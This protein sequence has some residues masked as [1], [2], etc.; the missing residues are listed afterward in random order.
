MAKLFS[1]PDPDA[2]DHIQV[3]TIHKSQGLEFDARILPSMRQL[4]ERRGEPSAVDEFTT[5]TGP[6]LLHRA[7]EGSRRRRCSH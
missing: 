7:Y 6:E 2:S 4:P 1:E 5:D 3:M